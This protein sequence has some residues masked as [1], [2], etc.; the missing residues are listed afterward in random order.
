MLRE[1]PLTHRCM[2]GIGVDAV[3]R[4]D[5]GS[6][7]DATVRLCFSIATARSSKR[8]AISIARSACSCIPWSVAAI[9]ALNRRGGPDRAGH[10]SIGRRPRV[11]HGSGRRR[12]AS[13]YRRPAGGRRRALDAYY[14]CPHHPRRQRSPNTPRVRLPQAGRGLVDR[15]IARTRRRCR[16]SRSRSATDGSTSRSPGPSAREAS[17]C[18][19]GT[20][21]M[22]SIGRPDGLAADAVVN[23]LVEAAS[24][25]LET[26]A[27]R[28]QV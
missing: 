10:E 1:C 27:S 5:E 23:N 24:W 18:E 4:G 28:A 19:P 20:A 11:L 13:P 17:W 7:D 21:P 12:S 8:S 26:L 14:Y 2:T 22:R 15:A 9:R 6:S 3:A 16:G 25:I